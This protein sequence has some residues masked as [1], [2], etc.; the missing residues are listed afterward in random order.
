MTLRPYQQ[1]CHDAVMAWIKRSSKP[2][3]VEAATGAGK[4]HLVASLASEVHRLSGKRILVMQPTSELVEQNFAKYPSAASIFSAS[5]G[6]KSTRH[7]VVFGTPQTIHNSIERFLSGYAMVVLDEAHRITPTVR[8]IIN[9]MRVR[10][11]NLRV[12]GLSATPYRLGSGYIYRIDMTKAHDHG[13]DKAREPYFD[14]LV[15]RVQAHELIEQGYLTRPII[16]SIGDA[17]DTSGLVL[18]KTG[19]WNSESVDRAFVGQG[20]KTSKIVAEVVAK[21]QDRKGVM[22]FAATVQHAKEVMDSLPSGLAAIV[23]GDTPAAE[24][25]DIIARFK[26]KR[27]K[28]LVNVS[29]LTTGFDAPHV[30]VI[31]LL[32]ATESVSLMQQ[33]IGRG[34]RI[35]DGKDECLIL[36][37]AGNVERHCPEGDIFDPRIEAASKPGEAGEM[38]VTCPLCRHDNQFKARPNPE[39]Y[40]IDDE[41]YFVDLDG[42]RVENEHGGHFPAHLGRRCQGIDLS[43]KGYPRC[44]H[45][46]ESKECESCGHQNDIAARHCEA[47]KG[48]I[49]NPNDKLVL[50]KREAEDPLTE[51]RTEPVL[52]WSCKPTTSWKGKNRIDV[53]IVTT[54][55]R[56]RVF[57]APDARHPDA[58]RSY[59]E[60]QRK[61][62]NGT[63]PPSAV[64]YRRD[65]SFWQVREYHV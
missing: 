59:A 18:E 58:V 47:C 57:L 37:Y 10:E 2:C 49:V 36:D 50:D 8:E 41:G 24:R 55:R 31:A 21:A 20:R 12:V 54:K 46:W 45:R 32:R 16:G 19:N 42:V 5:A 44:E 25:R 6:A 26:S 38:Q 22:L 56:M 40:G 7:P 17:Y 3:I 14:A 13:E 64:T 29:V 11:P 52:S 33:M 51:W 30:D 35:A 61:T 60:W 63:M 4:S 39:G 15:E 9:R 65:G 43:I 53:D 62:V 27:I 34:L 23:T 28:Y 1:R 48:E